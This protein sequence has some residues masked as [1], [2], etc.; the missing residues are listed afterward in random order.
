M[1]GTDCLEL[2]FAPPDASLTSHLAQAKRSLARDYR[3]LGRLPGGDY[4]SFPVLNIAF[5]H[6]SFV[7]ERCRSATAAH[8][9]TIEC[10]GKSGKRSQLKNSD[11]SRWSTNG[12]EHRHELRTRNEG[13]CSRQCR[14]PHIIERH[15]ER[16]FAGPIIRSLISPRPR[17]YRE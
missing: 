13:W 15:A 6:I 4:G 14:R 17:V 2:G 3:L 1:G 8:R 10:G 12:S 5:V 9:I 11:L 16:H 7:L